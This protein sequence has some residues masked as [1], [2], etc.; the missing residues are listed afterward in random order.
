MK[1]SYYPFIH[2]INYTLPDKNLTNEE[3][4][5]ECNCNNV[6]TLKKI[7]IS[8]RRIS[9]KNEFVSDMAKKASN[10]LF[11]NENI[12]P[13]EIDF[14]ILCTQSPDYLL[15]T[16]AC[17]LQNELGISTNCGAID[18]NLGCSGFI[19]G[20]A[21]ASSLI[22]NKVASNVLLI[23]AETYTK[24][25]NPLDKATRPI[26]GDG[27]A[28]TLIRGDSNA[29]RIGEFIL[30]TDG[31]GAQHL[32]IPAGGMRLPKSPQ[33]AVCM[34]DKYGNVRSLENLYMNGPEIFNFVVDLIPSLVEDILI[35]NKM[36]IDEIDLF[37]F[38]QAS[39][40]L[41]ETIRDK[42]K[43]PMDKFYINI[44]MIGNTVSASIPIALR[45]A[46]EE[47]KLKRGSKV[48]LAGF[49][50]GYSWGATLI[51]WPKGLLR[52]N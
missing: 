22:L 5:I 24:H 48:M 43:I 11:K 13:D 52:N 50:V 42:L 31:S 35:K 10:E 7:G 19:Y 29:Q 47:Q 37:V 2:S 28:A 30:G 20:L 38:H 36:D 3:L 51:R 45:L 8:E 33:T 49:G 34:R 1:E 46:E 17:I 9:G 41:L 6:S 4:A 21:I 23:M 12:H 25:I 18:F 27:A 39:R 26:F 16:T 15:P 40:Y 14:I 32:I 44:D